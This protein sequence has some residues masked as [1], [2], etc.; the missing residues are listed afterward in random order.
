MLLVKGNH[1]TMWHVSTHKYIS[2]C[3]C[4]MVVLVMMIM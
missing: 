1:A 4:A 2:V 3:A